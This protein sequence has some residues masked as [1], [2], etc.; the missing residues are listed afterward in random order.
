MPLP[1][2]PA[3]LSDWLFTSAVGV[4]MLAALLSAGEY[5]LA[6]HATTRTA[7]AVGADGPP[8]PDEPA[9]VTPPDWPDRLGRMG[10]ALTALGALLHVASVVLRG[11]ATERIPWANMYE[12]L[13]A[14]GLAAV[15]AWLY[16]LGRHPVRR[17]AVFVLLPISLLLFLAGNF[18]YTEVASVQPSLRSYWIVVHVT[19]AIMASGVFL[20][21]GVTSALHLIS[22]GGDRKSVV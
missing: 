15:C 20:I 21:S 11:V 1:T 3:V 16:V 8:P 13:S 12:Y 7:V 10:V 2:S 22:E 14:V 19:A 9:T 5:V 4:Y 17:V 6:R 18:L